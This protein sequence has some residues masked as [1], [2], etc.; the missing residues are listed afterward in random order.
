MVK[1]LHQTP[2]FIDIL[3]I[4]VYPRFFLCDFGVDLLGFLAGCVFG[5][6]CGRLGGRRYGRLGGRCVGE[7]FEKGWD[8]QGTSVREEENG[9][10]E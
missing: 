1:E 10:R 3:F 8:L 4:F 7:G 9:F 6:G 5:V 2:Q